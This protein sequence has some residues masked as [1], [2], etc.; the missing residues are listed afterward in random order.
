MLN[1]TKEE[2]REYLVKYQMINTDNKL[3]GNDGII[4][5][6]NRIQSIQVDPLDVVG[7]NAD[8]V[9]NNRLHNYK[10]Y[11]IDKALYEDRIL[12]DG[13]D[14]MMAIF[15]TED[16]P[17]FTHIR[18]SR[19]DSEIYTLKHRLQIEALDYIDDIL[20]MI[21]DGP[22]FSKDI[23]MGGSKKHHWGQM[24]VSSAA[25]DYLFFRG[26]ISVRSRK[27]QQKQYDITSNLIGDITSKESPY[28]TEEDFSEYYLLRRIKALGLASNKS[29]VHMSGAYI[30]KKIKREQIIKQLLGKDLIEEVLIEG[31]K[32]TYYIPKDSNV[33]ES[34]LVDKISFIAPL[35]NL[36]WDR[37]LLHDLFGFYYRWEVY[38]PIVK[39]EYGY[40][41][42]P[43][44]YRSNFIGRIEFEKHRN[45]EPLVIK[46]IWYEDNVKQTKKLQT[47]LDQAIKQFSRYV[48]AK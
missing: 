20:D 25:L 17:L 22:K 3:I 7:R 32:E 13:W 6:F 35:D 36:V 4:T 5:L 39:R 24:K 31:L 8:L 12:F 46:N 42:L 21:K 14:K 43:M 23:S 19:S 15:K 45:N 48:G 38:T 27:N 28:K 16:Y 34:E 26:D 10:K 11:D 1:W 47:K 40:Y 18:K 30:N 9:L 29:G 44:V 41:V 37:N 33:F 2:A